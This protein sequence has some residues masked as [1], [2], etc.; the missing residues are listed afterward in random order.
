MQR[1]KNFAM[2][3]KRL[4]AADCWPCGVTKFF[5]KS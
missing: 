2:N 1:R 3:L 4:E 5:D